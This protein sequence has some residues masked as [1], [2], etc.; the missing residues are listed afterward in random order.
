MSELKHGLDALTA[1]MH[2]SSFPGLSEHIVEYRPVGT[3]PPNILPCKFLYDR[4]RERNHK[5]RNLKKNILILGI[6]N[7]SS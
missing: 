1:P 5:E 3:G 6:K 7:Q 4:N 2:K